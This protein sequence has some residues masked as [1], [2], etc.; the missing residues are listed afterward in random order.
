M[1]IWFSGLTAAYILW[2][3]VITGRR[4]LKYNPEIPTPLF[5]LEE[6]VRNIGGIIILTGYQIVLV[7]TGRVEHCSEMPSE[8]SKVLWILFMTHWLDFHFYV[9]HRILHDV[10]FL[11]RHVHRIH[12]KSY[13]TNPISG[14][15]MH[16]VEHLIYFTSIL[17][18]CILPTPFWVARLIGIGIVSGP[19]ASHRGHLHRVIVIDSSFAHCL[20]MPKTR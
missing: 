3:F 13:N 9:V 11:Y 2:L 17:L 5:M 12:H 8:T 20:P 10:P 14:L 15:S 16:P 1:I 4:D 7:K 6:L 18:P 19:L